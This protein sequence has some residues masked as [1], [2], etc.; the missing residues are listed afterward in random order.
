MPDDVSTVHI[1]TGNTVLYSDKCLSYYVE[2]IDLHPK[3]QPVIGISHGSL[4]DIAI[5]TVNL[6]YF[7]INSIK[8]S[9]T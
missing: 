9:Y 4:N 6:K 5:L 7:I 2:K 3:F 1:K 8:H